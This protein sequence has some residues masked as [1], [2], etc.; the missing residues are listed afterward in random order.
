MGKHELLFFGKSFSFFS[1]ISFLKKAGFSSEKLVS[2]LGWEGLG[3]KIGSIT[4]KKINFWAGV[5]HEKIV[6]LP[7]FVYSIGYGNAIFFISRNK[8]KIKQFVTFFSSFKAKK[9]G[10]FLI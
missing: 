3:Y 6:K 5:P 1:F 9:K 10:F 4:K 8:Q 2:G 7:S